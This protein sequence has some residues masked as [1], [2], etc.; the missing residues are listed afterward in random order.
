[1]TAQSADRQ[2]EEIDLNF[3]PDMRVPLASR[4]GGPQAIRL[5]VAG[6]IARITLANGAAG[7]PI[8]RAFIA[9]LEAATLAL[10]CRDDVRAVLI[11]AE[12]PRFSV[13]G[14]MGMFGDSAQLPNRLRHWNA[15]INT[16]IARLSRIAAPSVVAVH[17]SVAG[18]AI[19]LMAHCDIVVASP[20]TRFVAAYTKIGLCPD[21]GG[22]YALSR[23]LG[24]ARTKRFYLLAEELDSAEALQTGMIDVVAEPGMHIAAAAEIAERWAAGPRGSYE[25]TRQIMLTANDGGFESQAEIETQWLAK[26][27]ASAN[28]REGVNA[29]LGRRAPR[30]RQRDDLV[31][32]DGN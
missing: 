32:S 5:S 23:R 15:I 12:G 10:S 17:G 14:D 21:L 16:S 26:L 6:G 4:P 8:T 19:S 27:S 13:G 31:S 3:D 30:F 1:M 29:F 28:F 9:D 18:G 2:P 7:N 22:S 11:E 24:T 25:A 20:E